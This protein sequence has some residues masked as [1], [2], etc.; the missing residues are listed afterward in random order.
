MANKKAINQALEAQMEMGRIE[1]DA[2]RSSG[3]AEKNVGT[4][5]GSTLRWR[6]ENAGEQEQTDLNGMRRP[7][8]M[9]CLPYDYLEETRGRHLVSGSGSAPSDLSACRYSVE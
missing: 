3:I 5:D 2:T 7:V 6:R 1:A 9:I 4:L 8:C